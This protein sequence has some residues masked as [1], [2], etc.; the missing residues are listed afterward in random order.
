MLGR[1]SLAAA[2]V[3]LACTAGTAR[4]AQPG[5][6]AAGGGCSFLPRAI[7][8]PGEGLRDPQRALDSTARPLR[9]AMLF[10]TPAGIRPA[11]SPAALY[12]SLAP[13]VERWF[14]A[15]SYGRARIRV[16]LAVPE[17]LTVDRL[18]AADAIAAASPLADLAGYDAV[19]A[20]LPEETRLGASV[21]EV[22]PGGAPRFGVVLAPHPTADAPRRPALWQVLAH[23]LGHVFGLPDLY[24]DIGN[25]AIGIHAGPWDP[26]SVPLGQNLLAW[27]AWQLGWLDSSALR[28]LYAGTAVQDLTAA[29]GSGG[30]KALVVPLSQSSALVAEARERTGLDAGLCGDGVLVYDVETDAV[31]AAPPL[32]VLGADGA[33]GGP[34]LPGG[35]LED[36]GV[37]V[38]VLAATAGGFRV[39][40]SR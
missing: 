28:C 5:L 25:G 14:A 22:L 3:A 1:R 40:V 12:A 2:A 16:S 39:R 21:A 8:T 27:H 17:W 23:E 38:D 34:L 31:P 6:P 20:V 26:M 32:R 4:A 35:S 18:D 33:C 10:V 29:G 37:R 9:L 36:A 19:V 7:E 13:P 11:E 30:V 24:A 15:A